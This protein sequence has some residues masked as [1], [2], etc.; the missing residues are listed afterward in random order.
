MDEFVDDESFK[1]KVMKIDSDFNAYIE[2]V[3]NES[4]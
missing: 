2:S 3:K 4:N 1:A